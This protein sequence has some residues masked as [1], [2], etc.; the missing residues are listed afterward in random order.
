[1]L[2]NMDIDVEDG[3]AVP[4]QDLQ[5]TTF[6]PRSEIVQAQYNLKVYERTVQITDVVSSQVINFN[7]NLQCLVAN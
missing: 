1:M 4:H 6:K 3:W 7:Y 5:I 2:K